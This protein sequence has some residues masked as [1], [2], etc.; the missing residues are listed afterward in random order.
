MSPAQ[1][2]RCCNDVSRVRWSIAFE[3]N[4]AGAL[5][6]GIQR[7]RGRREALAPLCGDCRTALM[8]DRLYT[9]EEREV[10]LANYLGIA[11]RRLW[12]ET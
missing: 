12:H 11:A 3:F 4:P 1:C 5:R 10:E 7:V 6:L 9:P 8:H 2:T